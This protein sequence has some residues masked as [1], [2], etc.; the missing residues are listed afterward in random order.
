MTNCITKLL[1]D[2]LII[3]ILS[4]IIT[5]IIIILLL[6]IDLIQSNILKST[7]KGK[8]YKVNLIYSTIFNSLK[9]YNNKRILYSQIYNNKCLNLIQ[10]MNHIQHQLLKL[11]VKLK[12][13][14][15]NLIKSFRIQIHK[16]KIK[17]I[18]KLSIQLKIELIV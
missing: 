18:K 6:Y 17:N 9:I 14:Y 12:L 7:V 3:H 11:F 4:F 5:K 2:Q 8:K 15:L 13:R 1:K 10:S 16:H